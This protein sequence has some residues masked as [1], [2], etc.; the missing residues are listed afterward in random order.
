[1]TRIEK[2]IKEI[3]K[4]IVIYSC[5]SDTNSDSGVDK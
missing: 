2:V 5:P 1:M 4:E 3:A